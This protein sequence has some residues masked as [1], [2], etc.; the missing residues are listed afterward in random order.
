MRWKITARYWHQCFHDET[1][2]P[3]M[4]AEILFIIFDS[5]RKITILLS[6]LLVRRQS[7]YTR[8][9]TSGDNGSSFQSSN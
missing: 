7:F 1:R 3:I 2:Q 5:Y 8:Y 4:L 6:I 9:S